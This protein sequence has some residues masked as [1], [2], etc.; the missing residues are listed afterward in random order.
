MATFPENLVT[1][2][3]Y[4]CV[5]I[6]F[7]QDL[8]EPL[9]EETFQ[10]NLDA[11]EIQW[12]QQG[13]RAIWCRIPLSLSHFIPILVKDKFVYH[14]AKRQVAVMYKW[15]SDTETDN[16]PVYPYTNVGVS[17]LV[18]DSQDR[19]L[20]VQEKYT[21]KG[22]RFWKFPGGVADQGEEIGQTVEREVFEETGIR[23]SF[24]SI[25]TMRHWHGF[26]F[27]CSD[28][29]IT[30]LM[31]VDESRPDALKLS[32][33]SHEI[34]DVAW[35]P[36]Q[37]LIPQLTQSNRFCL[38]KYWFAK[39]SSVGITSHKVPFVLGGDITVYSTNKINDNRDDKKE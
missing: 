9:T 39:K 20:V 25:L 5:S 29:F 33:C 21:F 7:T 2:D 35:I 16:I 34:H 14:H 18:I 13:I 4:N 11:S 8:K 19:A 3:M 10:S 37:E 12:K 24:H 32:K 31:T 17:G 6:D 27:G 30:C 28:M 23:T 15:I 26:Q 1:K 38:E 36:V 22:G